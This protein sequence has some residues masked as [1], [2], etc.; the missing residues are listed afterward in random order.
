M[1]DYSQYFGEI[2]RLIDEKGCVT[3][4]GM[5]CGLNISVTASKW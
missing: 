4:R 3:Y 2:D 1:V 5:A